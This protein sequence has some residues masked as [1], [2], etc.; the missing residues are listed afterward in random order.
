MKIQKGTT[1]RHRRAKC[2]LP[3][4]NETDK[5]VVT[6]VHRGVVHYRFENESKS[7]SFI[8]LE[9]F[10]RHADDVRNPVEPFRVSANWIDYAHGPAADDRKPTAVE[11]LEL[12]GSQ[13]LLVPPSRPDLVREIISVAG[14]YTGSFGGDREDRLRAAHA[15]RLIE[16]GKA[17][18]A[19]L[20]EG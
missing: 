10:A 12:C 15:R 3:D 4:G 20:Q 2:V 6:R 7:K 5:C 8:R 1:F 18:L 14:L 19:S 11:L 16:R 17:W 13:S 9:D